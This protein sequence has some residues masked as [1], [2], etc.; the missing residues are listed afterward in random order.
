M[1]C[2]I[3]LRGAMSGR[4]SVKTEKSSKP[5]GLLDHSNLRHSICATGFFV[6][7]SCHRTGSLQSTSPIF[8][9]A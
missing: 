7:H 4:I 9:I 1:N 5:S 6:R 2:R 3:A 8:Q